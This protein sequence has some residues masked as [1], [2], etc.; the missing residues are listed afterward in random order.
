MCVCV[1]ESNG[2]GDVCNIKTMKDAKKKTRKTL[3]NDATATKHPRWV[4]YYL[5]GP[6]WPCVD[7]STERTNQP[8]ENLPKTLKVGLTAL[9]W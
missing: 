5:F 6:A 1:T 3:W 4:Q 7:V 9:Q 2:E 8:T